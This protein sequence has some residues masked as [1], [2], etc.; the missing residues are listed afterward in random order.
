MTTGL[1]ATQQWT[2]LAIVFY[3]GVALLVSWYVFGVR[4]AS[5]FEPIGLFLF[6][7]TLFALP[8]PVRYCLTREIEGDVSTNLEAFAP[9]LP[10][11]LVMTALSLAV[12]AMGYFSSAAR[13][14]GDRVPLM[15]DRSSAGTGAGVAA[16][17][18]VSVVLI[19]FLTESLGGIVPFLLLG[20]KSSEETFGRGYLAVGF[21]WLVVALSLIHI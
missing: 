1:I 16:L 5:L 7:M 10:I 11:S 2:L 20:Y 19:Y 4:R 15:R 8:L 21:P 18:G 13:R 14:L 9:Y 3:L 6:F 17:V 12:F